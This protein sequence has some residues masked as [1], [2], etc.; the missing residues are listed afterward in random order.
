VDDISRGRG[1]MLSTVY[2][3]LEAAIKQGESLKPERFFT[4]AQREE[5]A[6]AYRKI[7][8]G[9]LAD[10]RSLL[11]GKYDYGEL[12]IFRALSTR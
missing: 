2:D 4:G 3:H 11:D 5:I 8:D 9:K 7:P 10:V 6:A 12:R 1:F